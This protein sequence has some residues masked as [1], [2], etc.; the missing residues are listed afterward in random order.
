MRLKGHGLYVLNLLALMIFGQA[1]AYDPAN[2]LV[3]GHEKPREIEKVQIVQ[4]LGDKIDLSTQFVDDKGKDVVIGDFFKSGKPVLFTIIYYNCPMLCNL[5]LNGV[6]KALAELE[7]SI[8]D[9]FELVALTMNHREGVELASQK[10]ASYIKDYGRPE[11]ADGWHFLT[12]TESNIRKIADQVG[13]GYEWLP[14]QKEYAHASAAIIMTPEGQISRY[15]QGIEF[16]PQTFKFA[17]MEAS[18]G[19]I[20]EFIDRALSLC[21]VFDPNK[22]K[23]TIYSWRLMQTSGVAIILAMGLILIPLWRREVRASPEQR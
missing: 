21:F 1:Q 17:L 4:K 8:G 14:D 5:H 19:T 12:G 3:T 10:K 16:D 18:N 22:N 15:L 23:Y 20:G 11:S 6:T 9:E 7:W 13:F 2:R